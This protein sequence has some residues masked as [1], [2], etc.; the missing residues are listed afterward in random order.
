[1]EIFVLM[2]G[3]VF[4]IVVTKYPREEKN[5]FIGKKLLKEKK[6]KENIIKKNI[7]EREK[8]RRPEGN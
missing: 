8:E 6:R 5:Y 4:Q 1:M 7:L 2:N 3:V